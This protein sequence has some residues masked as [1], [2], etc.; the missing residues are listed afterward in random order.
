[1]HATYITDARN[2]FNL[3]DNEVLKKLSRTVVDLFYGR[4]ARW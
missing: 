1:M 4:P 2:P 3:I